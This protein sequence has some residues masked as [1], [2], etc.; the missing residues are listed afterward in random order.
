MPSAEYWSEI[1]RQ[2]SE[3]WVEISKRGTRLGAG[4]LLNRRFALTASHCL[5]SISSDDEQFEL[6][7]PSGLVASG[8]V[9]ELS[10]GAD[11]ALIDILKPHGGTLILPKA[12]RAGSG[13]KWS[14]P[15]RPGPSDPY[16]S[17][18]VLHGA[19][20]YRCEGGNDIEALQLVCS[21]DL[22]DFS[23]YSGAPVERHAQGADPALLGVLLEQYLD[24]QAPGRASGVLFAA[25]IAEVLRCFDSFGVTHLLKVLLPESEI[26]QHC[27][28]TSVPPLGS[29]VKATHPT[30]ELPGPAPGSA[31]KSRISDTGSM[32]EALHEWGERGLLDP[33]DAYKLSRAAAR[34]LI[35]TDEIGD[36]R[37]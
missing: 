14:A 7:F 4:F 13:D 9:H 18:D 36:D 32:L 21:L 25:T 5:R 29:T 33:M 2:G 20:T 26:P 34:R 35:G 22:G 1:S 23:G 10:L 17:G 30:A 16:L 31:V 19:M 37:D 15:Y 27:H 6:S 11:L 28:P 12:D 24:R 3:Y 8:R